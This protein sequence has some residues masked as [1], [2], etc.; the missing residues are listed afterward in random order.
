[1]G[2]VLGIRGKNGVGKSTLVQQMVNLT[3]STSGSITLFG[4]NIARS[5]QQVSIHVGYMPQNGYAL[6]S[7]TVGEA[8]FF[9][10]HLRDTT[11]VDASRERDRLLELW[12]ISELRN[13]YI[14]RLSGGQLRLLQLALAMAGE[15][16]VRILD[17]PTNDLDPRCPDRRDSTYLA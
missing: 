14:S 12:Q 3:R 10:A 8:C 16:S 13:K 17:E 2:E 4:R 9:T 5:P 11:R 7:L 15:P 1:Q 6:A